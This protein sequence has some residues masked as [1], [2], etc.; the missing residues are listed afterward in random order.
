MPFQAHNIHLLN[1]GVI[2]KTVLI[3]GKS[4]NIADASFIRTIQK[5]SGIFC[6]N[7]PLS[8][9]PC[10]SSSDFFKIYHK[11]YKSNTIVITNSFY[12]ENLSADDEF[13]NEFPLDDEFAFENISSEGYSFSRNSHILLVLPQSEEKTDEIICNAFS[14]LIFNDNLRY[15]YQTIS[16][17]NIELNI[18]EKKLQAYKFAVNQH[19]ALVK[20]GDTAD[21]YVFTAAEDAISSKELCKATISEIFDLFGDDVFTD[22][23]NSITNNTVNMLISKGIKIAT[24]ESCTAG[25]VSSAITSVPNSSS[26]FEIGISSYS[27]RI[28]NAALGVSKETLNLYGAVSPETAIEMAIGIKNLSSSDIG[29][30][31]TGVAGP[32]KSEDKQVGTVYIALVD[33]N[34][35]W[36]IKLD[37]SHLATRDAIRKKAAFEAIELLRRYLT[38]LPD[39]LPQGS[40]LSSPYILLNQ[41]PVITDYSL[42]NTKISEIAETPLDYSYGSEQS[43]V[44]TL[45]KDNP[46]LS[47]KQFFADLK[48]DTASFFSNKNIKIIKRGFA[49]LAALAILI[50]SVSV[51]S[52]F[53]GKS[54]NDKIISEARSIWNSDIDHTDGDNSKTFQNLRKLNP[55]IAAWITIDNSKIDNPICHSDNNEYYKNHN[56]LGKRSSYGSLYFNSKVNLSPGS[57]SR[58]LIIYGNTPKDGSMFST[59]KSYKAFSYLQE[60][61][62][63]KLFQD[64]S[65]LDYHILSV[66]ITSDVPQENGDNFS[67]LKTDFTDI[68]DMYYWI[69]EISQ[70]SLYNTIAIPSDKSQFITLVTDSNEFKNAKLVV[71][72]FYDPHLAMPENYFTTLKVNPS[73]RY[74]K[75]WYDVHSIEDP[76]R[77]K[78]ETSFAQSSYDEPAVSI[79]TNSLIEDNSSASVSSEI[80]SSQS[81]SSNTASS[82]VTPS[83]NSNTASKPNKPNNTSSKTT[84]KPTSSKTTSTVSS[85]TSSK[86]AESVPTPKPESNTETS[87]ES[88]T[89]EE[90]QTTPDNT[91]E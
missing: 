67:Y 81:A 63:I 68:D 77:Q 80:T 90:S 5:L 61:S 60:H 8:L 62:T 86:K 11:Y 58:N 76:F 45:K 65:S 4:E 85:G 84:S 25:L 7:E 54:N 82:K 31:V 39:V 19:I 24:A 89:H 35:A 56:L 44:D 1:R 52:Y 75:I 12:C 41:Q 42:K 20:N 36:V 51:F 15:T 27:N 72:A 14:S 47:V 23:L 79:E 22:T 40:P 91:P 21:I 49:L 30:S 34:N 16:V 43:E 50:S 37:L 55:D 6:G 70:R 64:S 88:Q 29:I 69:D 57:E 9:I 33:K 2:L 17:T 71:I 18:I 66:M 38:C 48:Y 87:T 28:K 83:A 78:R 26:V 32:T 74:P 3:Y 53:I 73:P 59:I 10:N 46:L 13:T